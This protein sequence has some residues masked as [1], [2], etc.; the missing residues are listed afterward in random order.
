MF[1]NMVLIGIL[2]T[3]SEEVPGGWRKIQNEGLLD[4]YCYL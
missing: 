2:E 3:N 1:T 4:M